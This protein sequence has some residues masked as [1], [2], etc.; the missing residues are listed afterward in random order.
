M[1]RRP[2]QTAVANA[3]AAG[4]TDGRRVR[5]RR[6]TFDDLIYGCP[7][8]YPGRLPA[9][10]LD[11]VHEPER[12]ADRLLVHRARRSTSPRPA[13]RSSRRSRS[14][15]A[16]SA[17]PNGYA[18]ES[19]TSMASPHL[20]G[21]RRAGAVA[22]AS[23]TRTTTACCPTTSRRTCARPPDTASLA[24]QDRPALPEVVRLRRR[25]RP[26]RRS[27]T[28]PPAAHPTTP[29][30]PPTTQPRRPRTRP[31]TSPSSRTTAIPTATPRGD[32]GRCRVSRDRGS[33][34]ERDCEVLAGAQL[35]RPRRVPVHDR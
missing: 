35:Q 21:A 14:G 20:A 17:R 24:R 8:A 29:R 2:S 26:E 16:S 5:Q 12:R 3:S 11:D 9:G 27:L 4:V 18:A 19:G 31:R 32:R 6:S 1:S 7:V 13:T 33:A 22:R 34:P 15:R 25:Q 23:P 28:N 10:P 30:S